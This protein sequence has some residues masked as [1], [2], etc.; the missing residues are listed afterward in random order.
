MI[1]LSK[2]RAIL[3]ITLLLLLVALAAW[4][5][6]KK[7]VEEPMN[8]TAYFTWLFKPYDTPVYH[9]AKKI[10]LGQA[11]TLEELQALP[12]GVNARYEQETTL[13]FHALR[14]RNLNAIDT[15]LAAG[16]DPYLVDK[17]SLNSVQSFAYYLTLLGQPTVDRATEEPYVNQLLHLY[18]K[19]GG[20]PNHRLKTKYE[21]YLIT[22][23]ARM[24][25]YE[26]METLLEA[27]A[28]PWARDK[29]GETAMVY[30]ASS[31]QAH[32]YLNQLID[33]GYFED[34]EF[35]KLNKFIE[36]LHNYTDRTEE[37]NLA[38][39]AIGRRV[40]KRHPDFPDNPIT[41]KLFLGPIPW[42][43]I[44]KER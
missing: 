24:K 2:Q 32:D 19:H 33:R 9:I 16:A 43:E 35:K 10:E 25:N 34:V 14:M 21:A 3:L 17:P 1:K 36:S 29:Y 40:L 37:R 20:D 12:E 27:G 28:D 5:E 4:W 42:D 11:I 26:G 6:F 8:R 23:V 22:M 31:G 30:L 41:E 44:A 15:L 13:L 38:D 18:L 39:Q 7:P